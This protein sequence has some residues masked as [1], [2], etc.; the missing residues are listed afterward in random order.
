[1][2]AALTAST[3]PIARTVLPELV[4]EDS[5]ADALCPQSVHGLLM[6][7]TPAL[8]SSRSCMWE[9]LITCSALQAHQE[10]LVN[11]AVVHAH[12]AALYE[13]LLQQNL[14][15]LVE[16]FSRVEVAHLAALI[17]LPLQTVLDKLSQVRSQLA[18]RL[19]MHCQLYQ[20]GHANF[21][22]SCCSA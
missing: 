15:R 16:P 7:E 13:A 4:S 8:A 19:Q 18:I 22:R 6:H 11:D 9:T 12:L 1:M 10:E 2:R 3:L 5:W 17:K 20:L 21:C 14:A